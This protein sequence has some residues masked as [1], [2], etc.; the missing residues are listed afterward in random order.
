MPAGL[1][2]ACGRRAIVSPD[3]AR[4][5]ARRSSPE[6]SKHLVTVIYSTAAASA[7]RREVIHA[8]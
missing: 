3:R 6:A 2:V 8:A 5:S 7:S 4:L 1:R